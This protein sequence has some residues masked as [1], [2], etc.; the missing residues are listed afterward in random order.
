MGADL[1]AIKTDAA[2]P[3]GELPVYY[4][5][6]NYHRVVHVD[7]VYGGCSPTLGNIVMTVFS[8]RVPLPDK[9]VNDAG[10]NEI[11]EKR[12]VK[13]GIENELEASLVLELN[14]ARIIRDWL[15]STIK[16]AEALV[17]K[18]QGK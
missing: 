8:H 9:A 18:V 3:S 11:R 17:Q 7:G 12:V 16:N 2:I 13:Y 1:K 15:D 14:T 6:S 4:V 10:G 5:K